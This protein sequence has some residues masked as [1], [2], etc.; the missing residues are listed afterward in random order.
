MTEEKYIDWSKAITLSGVTEVDVTD[1]VKNAI[2]DWIERVGIELELGQPLG[3]DSGEITVSDPELK[4]IVELQDTIILDHFP[5]ITVTR[6]RDNIRATNANN[7]LTLVEETNF[8]IDKESGIIKLTGELS[9][10]NLMR[11][12]EVFTVGWNTV[13]VAY[14]YGFA[15][16]PNYLRAFATL[17]ATKALKVWNIISNNSTDFQMLKMGDY[18]KQYG[19]MADRFSLLQ[20]DIDRAKLVLRSKLGNFA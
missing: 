17:V 9:D 15:T 2:A 14:T 8:E 13:D 18:T 7:I 3:F 10:S 16:I 12:I 11:K 20:I 5:I 4:T 19:K 1:A 6:L